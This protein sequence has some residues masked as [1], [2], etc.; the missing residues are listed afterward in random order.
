MSIPADEVMRA[1]MSCLRAT[2]KELDTI[3]V[4]GILGTVMLL[5]GP[6]ETFRADVIKWLGLLPAAYRSPEGAFYDQAIYD[7]NGDKWGTCRH[8]EALFVLAT[9]LDL[10]VRYGPFARGYDTSGGIVY[11]IK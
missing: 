11:G 10:V 3:E 2:G 9:G 8:T 5:P 4:P 7:K 6:L 1:F